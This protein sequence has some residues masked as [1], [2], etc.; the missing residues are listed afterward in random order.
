MKLA[1]LPLTHGSST[2][3]S[4]RFAK[5]EIGTPC[6]HSSTKQRVKRH[7]KKAARQHLKH[8]LDAALLE[9]EEIR[10]DAITES[11]MESDIESAQLIKDFEFLYENKILDDEPIGSIPNWQDSL[12]PEDFNMEDWD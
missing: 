7:A 12:E 11:D 4:T 3:R 9:D 2:K 8:E 1:S 6:R 5:F 10:R